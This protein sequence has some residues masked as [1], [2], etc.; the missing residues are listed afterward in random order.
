MLQSLIAQGSILDEKISLNWNGRTFLPYQLSYLGIEWKNNYSK[1]GWSFFGVKVTV[2][3][4]NT[5]KFLKGIKITLQWYSNCFL[6]YEIVVG[7]Y[8]I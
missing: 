8:S 5:N 1:Y 4:Q 6:F 7:Y 2:T 3:A